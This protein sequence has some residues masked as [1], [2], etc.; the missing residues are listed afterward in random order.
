M[1]TAG[2]NIDISQHDLCTSQ[3][4]I[5]KTQFYENVILN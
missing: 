3:W 1:S 5:P 4:C 2:I